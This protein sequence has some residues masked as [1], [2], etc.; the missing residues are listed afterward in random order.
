MLLLWT[1][2]CPCDPV[3]QSPALLRASASL[4]HPPMTGLGSD[5]KGLLQPLQVLAQMTWGAP[6][7]SEFV[8]QDSTAQSGLCPSSEQRQWPFLPNTCL[9][10]RKTQRR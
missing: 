7:S 4:L 5:P 9:L 10:H 8:A 6:Q 3:T 2:C 1:T